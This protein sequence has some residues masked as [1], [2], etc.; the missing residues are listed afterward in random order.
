MVVM[1]QKTQKV[2]NVRWGMAMLIGLG[3]L[4]SYLD[5]FNI[6]VAGAMM[7]TKYGWSATKLGFLF[8]AFSWSYAIFQV[9]MAAILD[10]IGVKWMQRVCITLWGITSIGT[11][12][13]T[14]YAGIW[15]MRLLLGV[16]EA[17]SFSAASK[18]T[19]YWFPKQERGLATS[20]FDGA[21]MFGNAVGALL[22][23]VAIIK[24]G[25]RGAFWST[26]VVNLVY[27]VFFWILYRDP[28]ESKKLTKE[29]YEY[30]RRGGAQEEGRD[31]QLLSNI[32]LMMGSS[33]AWG[34]AIAK[35]SAG[36]IFYM[37]LTWMP[38]YITKA[39]HM[40][41]AKGAIYLA[42]PWLVATIT[43]FFIGGITVDYFVR[44]GYNPNNVRRSVFI[45]G[46]VISA[47]SM[48]L[49]TLT[50]NPNIV[51]VFLS[52]AVGGITCTSP[53]VWAIS[54]L[55]APKGMVG[56]LGGFINFINNIA[57]ILAPIVTGVLIDATGSYNT[58]FVVASIVFLIGILS[59]LL[60]V[61]DINKPI[62]L[63]IKG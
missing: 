49:I 5:R 33:R 35:A 15:V 4:I 31:S 23:S 36:Y 19:S 63:K 47:I 1:E 38:S 51:V 57:G 2:G 18:G 44:K 17:P 58:G 56:S 43:D 21:S 41:L 50:S 61:G 7:A 39:L 30:I 45:V 13:I 52:L 9:P 40:T 27:A 16:C 32:G 26:G 60:L 8:S 53:V 10:K 42:I 20:C 37:L 54:G 34:L 3:L 22:V 25:W 59:Y 28:S 14:G 6:S 11:G 12:F 24:W 55:I 29:E 48:G 62:E 46:T